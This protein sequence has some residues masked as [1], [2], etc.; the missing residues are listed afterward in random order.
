[1]SD[2]ANI[3]AAEG[4]T[5]ESVNTAA[6]LVKLEGNAEKKNAG[7]FVLDGQPL[8]TKDGFK[9][10]S[11]LWL[12]KTLTYDQGFERLDADKAQSLDIKATVRDMVPSVDANGNFA[13][14][15]RPT[16]TYYRPTVHAM[17]QIGNWADTGTW[18]V[19]NMLDNPQ[20]YKGRQKYARDRV[21]AETLA[22]VIR[23][24]FRR[25]DQQ[26]S[27]FW[28]ARVDG[29]LRA[30]L[31]DRF[32]VVDNRWFLEKLKAFI[33]GGRLSHWRGDGD[34][35]FGNV[36]IPDT[37]REEKDSDYGG[38]LSIGNS[39]IGERRVSSMPSIFRAIC[40]NGCIWGQTKGKGIKQVHRGAINLEHLALEIK[41]NLNV[42]IPLL[43]Q[44]I[45]RFLNTRTY[46]WDGCTIK[47]VIAQ[48]A[49]EFKLAKGQASAVLKGWNLE[50]KLT[51]ELGHTLFGVINAITRAGQEFDNAAWVSFDEIGGE[52]AE[53]EQKDV[54]TVVKRAKSLAVK[55][56][57]EMFA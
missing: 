32:A 13:F 15:Y 12:P 20:D 35:V 8:A 17:G 10:V 18:F 19:Q 9:N 3:L 54:D 45:D 29:T 44:G 47:P 27:F 48:V 16:E 43:P 37:I 1:M 22:A 11:A 7:Q 25:L 49:K 6:G 42:Q 40:M 34:T 24:G 23:N 2:F 30:M 51:P 55:E 50:S 21:D 28:R 52:L 46:A 26:K 56:V 53:Y 4:L 31:T 33:P 41:E 5:T 36:L 39:E 38:M 57:E 14:L